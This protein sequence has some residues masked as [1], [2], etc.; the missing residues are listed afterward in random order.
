MVRV[1]WPTRD[2]GQIFRFTNGLLTLTATVDGVPVPSGE[3]LVCTVADGDLYSEFA[4]GP[5]P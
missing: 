5:E 1:V 3:A 4:W 2:T